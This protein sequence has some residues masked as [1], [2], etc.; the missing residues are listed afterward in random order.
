MQITNNTFEV[1]KSFTSINPS[2]YINTGNIIKTISPQKTI[3]ARADV[4]ESF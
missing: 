1:L 4:D 2:I 3:I